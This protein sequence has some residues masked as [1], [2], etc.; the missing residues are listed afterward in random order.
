MKS[1]N[2]CSFFLGPHGLTIVVFDVW[3]PVVLIKVGKCPW[4]DCNFVVSAYMSRMF[5]V[6]NTLPVGPGA[7]AIPF[8]KPN[9]LC[10]SQVQQPLPHHNSKNSGAQRFLQ[11]GGCRHWCCLGRWVWKSEFMSHKR[12]KWVSSGAFVLSSFKHLGGRKWDIAMKEMLSE[13]CQHWCENLVAW[14]GWNALKYFNRGPRKWE[15]GLKKRWG[16]RRVS[17]VKLC[18]RCGKDRFDL[19]LWS[20]ILD[21]R[22][23]R[24]CEC[25]YNNSL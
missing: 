22:S 25:V 7:G 12:E 2:Q 9:I 18:W 6:W 15:G 14:Q 20:Q 1:T 3:N 24:N 10:V 17:A 11:T 4:M 13:N 16:T 23:L 21:H 8:P 19:Q 5:F